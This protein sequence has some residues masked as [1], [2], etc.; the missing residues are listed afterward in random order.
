MSVYEPNSR[1]LWEI[2]IFCFNMKK[3]VAEVRSNALKY[4]WH[5][6]AA[7]SERTCWVVSTLQEQWFWHQRPACWWKREGFHKIQNWRHY[8]MKARVKRKKNLQ[9]HWEWLNKPFQNTWK[10]MGMIQKQENWMSYD[11]KP[12]DVER[13]LFACEQ[14][15]ERQRRKRFLA[16]H[17]DWGRKMGSLR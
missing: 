13:C 2:L 9:D 14:L 5:V 15:L 4:L 10:P 12:R 7:I 11:V 3:S 8:F 1:H 16:S 6:K 17:C